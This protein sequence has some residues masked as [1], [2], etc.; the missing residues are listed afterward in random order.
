MSY[1]KISTSDAGILKVVSDKSKYKSDGKE[2]AKIY[3]ARRNK[4]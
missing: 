4:K 1:V 3:F 2:K